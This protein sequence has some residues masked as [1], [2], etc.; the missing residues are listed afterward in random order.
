MPDPTPTDLLNEAGKQEIIHRAKSDAVK[1]TYM[2]MGFLSLPMVGI[3]ALLTVAAAN[4]PTFS[5]ANERLTNTLATMQPW[6]TT[7]RPS[8]S[9]YEEPT[10]GAPNV[11]L[12]MQFS[13]STFLKRI[14]GMGWTIEQT[15]MMM[16]VRVPNA[17]AGEPDIRYYTPWIVTTDPVLDEN[18]DFTL[19]FSQH[20][21][22]PAG[23]PQGTLTS[24]ASYQCEIRFTMGTQDLS[25]YREFIIQT[26][27]F[28]YTGSP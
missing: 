3:C 23:P 6:D 8:W 10:S 27:W 28:D 19:R 11:Y 18:G 16:R 22:P 14:L 21:L 4:I 9:I 24:G 20:N 15:K 12:Q 1:V 5:A 17:T 13:A 2:W 7:D 25:Y 26:D